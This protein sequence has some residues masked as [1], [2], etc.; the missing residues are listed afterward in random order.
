MTPTS[1]AD[2]RAVGSTS[3]YTGKPCKHGHTAKRWTIDGAC[4]ECKATSNKRWWDNNTE[5]GRELVYNWRNNNLDKHREMVNR[6]VKAWDIRNPGK[7][8]SYTANR[9]AKLLD[10]TPAWADR[11]EIQELYSLAQQQGLQVDHI[12]PLNNPFV[13]GLHVA[14]N[15]QLLSPLENRIK[16]NQFKEKY[17][18]A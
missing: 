17:D 6:A 11:S 15:M 4:S 13:C 9:R 2:A 5:H 3:Y 8:N 12:I 18:E 16:S 1:R 10:A 7:R 14:N